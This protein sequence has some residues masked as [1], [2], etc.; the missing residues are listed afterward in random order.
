MTKN[1]NLPF[2]ILFTDTVCNKTVAIASHT[3]VN[4]SGVA[5][6]GLAHGVAM[7]DRQ[8]PVST[9]INPIPLQ[10][11]ITVVTHGEYAVQFDSLTSFNAIALNSPVTSL[12]GKLSTAVGN[13][14]VLLGGGETPRLKAKSVAADGIGYGLITLR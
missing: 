6:T 2:R 7:C 8:L 5:T 1:T 13:A 14:A 9:D 3:L 12:L 4:A 11:C 10:E